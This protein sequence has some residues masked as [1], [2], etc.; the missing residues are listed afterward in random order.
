[1]RFAGSARGIRGFFHRGEDR[2]EGWEVNAG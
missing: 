2:G 1:L